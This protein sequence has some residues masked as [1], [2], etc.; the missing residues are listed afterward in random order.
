M[1]NYVKV[2]R[3]LEKTNPL[4]VVDAV[5]KVIVQIKPE[6]IWLYIF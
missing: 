2:L 4:P 3:E 6:N 1:K 5:Q